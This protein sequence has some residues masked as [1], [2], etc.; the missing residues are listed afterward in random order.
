MKKLLVLVALFSV[1]GCTSVAELITTPTP[2]A[3]AAATSWLE[4]IQPYLDTETQATRTVT[5]LLDYPTLGDSVWT[6][7]ATAQ[8]TKYRE[9]D[10]AL[11]EIVP[12][13]SCQETHELLLSASDD[14]LLGLEFL[15]SGI[16]QKDSSH[17]G[18]S[19]DFLRAASTKLKLAKMLMK[20]IA[21]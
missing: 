14:G 7:L 12:P 15:L 20:D 1:I 5:A 10:T 13:K 9:A 2:S 17:I 3:L 21:P 6:N 19:K 8:I 4:E 18:A 16:L 11:R